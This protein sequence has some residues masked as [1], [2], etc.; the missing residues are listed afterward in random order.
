MTV[1]GK[2]GTLG[3]GLVENT[4]LNRARYQIMKMPSCLIPRSLCKRLSCQA[5]LMLV[6]R[7]QEDAYSEL[8]SAIL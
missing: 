8:R 3:G 4:L 2:R 7:Y 6:V 5:G 1:S